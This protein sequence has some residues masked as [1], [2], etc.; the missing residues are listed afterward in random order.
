[1]YV[2]R[3]P[4]LQPGDPCCWTSKLSCE[5]ADEEAMTSI[6][7]QALLFVLSWA[8]STKQDSRLAAQQALKWKTIVLKEERV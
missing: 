7:P 6:S 4:T 1:M 8:Y 5:V 2:A 3:I